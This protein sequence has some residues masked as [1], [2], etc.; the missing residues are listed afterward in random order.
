MPL[1]VQDL[2]GSILLQVLEPLQTVTITSVVISIT[3][4][5]MSIIVSSIAIILAVTSIF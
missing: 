4:V 5:M 2:G 1:R 3:V